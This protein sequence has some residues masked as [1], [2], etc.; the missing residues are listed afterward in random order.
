MNRLEDLEFTD[1]VA[2]ISSKFENIQ[3][4][5]IKEEALASKTAYK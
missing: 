4:K 3:K 5:T 1:D 2:F